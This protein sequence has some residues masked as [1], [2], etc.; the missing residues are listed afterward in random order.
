MS[1][2]LESY[3]ANYNALRRSVSD[4]VVGRTADNVD[5]IQQQMRDVNRAT[6]TE[7]IDAVLIDTE[8]PGTALDFRNWVRAE[9]ARNGKTDDD[10]SK[11]IFGVPFADLDAK[12][13]GIYAGLS[14]DGET[15]DGKRQI[16][17]ARAEAK[18]RRK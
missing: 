17:A 8:T 4:K 5:V 11:E 10:L 12:I 6:G 15:G 1:D 9:A 13:I 18:R 2:S 16:A 7:H 3:R 14:A